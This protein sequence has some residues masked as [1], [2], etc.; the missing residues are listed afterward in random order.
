MSTRVVSRANE[1]LEAAS[2]VASPPLVY[3]RLMQVIADPRA[4]VADIG[5]VISEDQALTARVLRLVN[6]ALFSLPWE[7]DT[8][9]EAVR[10]VGISQIRDL[11]TAT[12]IIS[13]FDDLPEDLVNPSSFWSHSL[14]CGV[15]ARLVARQR[16][17][18]NPERF[19]VA[20]L[21]HDIGRLIMMM[22]AAD[23]VREALG[24][25][26]HTGIDLTEA[27]RN[28]VG[29][30]HTLVGGKLLSKWNFPAALEQAVRY[31][32]DPRRADR[33]PTETA[34]VHVADLMASVLGWGSSGRVTAPS[35]VPSAWDMLG[36]EPAVLP[37]MLDDAEQQWSA[38][39][40]LIEGTPG[41]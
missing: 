22:Y 39:V 31:H 13:M 1:L 26:R 30:D 40:H 28:H 3:Q 32:H 7:V 36:V 9:T 6:S 20:G 16:G 34:T 15:I 24:D 8:V 18:D 11:A 19:L 37:R 4:G 27:E 25:A 35:L 2:T 41:V 23:Q 10:V 33:F 17:E 38:V 14:G 21:L 5:R 12:S 29:C